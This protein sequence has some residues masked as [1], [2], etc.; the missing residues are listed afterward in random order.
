MRCNRVYGHA[1]TTTEASLASL[2]VLQSTLSDNRR[3]V[4]TALK[5][6]KSNFP[7]IALLT[8]VLQHGYREV[9]LVGY[10]LT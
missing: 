3:S 8:P 1:D 5:S 6:S 10:E 7:E 2:D 4:D 9:H